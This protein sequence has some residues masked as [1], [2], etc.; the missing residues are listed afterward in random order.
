MKDI[1]QTWMTDKAMPYEEN[2][3]LGTSASL[4]LETICTRPAGSTRSP[5]ADEKRKKKKK[6]KKKETTRRDLFL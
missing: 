3:T 1:N 6:M 5:P 2:K 4:N